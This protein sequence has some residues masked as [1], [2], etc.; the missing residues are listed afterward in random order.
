MGTMDWLLNQIG[1]A[2]WGRW[3]PGAPAAL[4]GGVDVPEPAGTP[5]YAL[6]TGTLTGAGYFYHGG[7][8]FSQQETGAGANPG[9]GVVTENVPGVGQVYYQHIDL[10]PGIPFCQSGNCNGYQVQAGQLL[11]YSR[12]NPG[13][14]EVGINPTWGGIWGTNN[15]PALWQ[16]DPRSSLVALAQQNAGASQNGG[17]NPISGICANLPPSISFVLCGIAPGVTTATD[18]ITAAAG[19][20]CAPWDIQCILGDLA[21][22]IQKLLIFALGAFLMWFGF[23]LLVSHEAVNIALQA[24]GAQSSG[25]SS[26]KKSSKSSSSG[27]ARRRRTSGSRS[28]AQSSAAPSP[29][30]QSVSVNGQEVAAQSSS[31]PS[32]VAKAEQVAKVAAVA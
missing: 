7:P 3:M 20:Q 16:S 25:G 21:P 1:K 14:V 10:A 12:A 18:S 11:G 19:K 31:K 5:I 2:N 27:S 6:G 15:N 22:L 29:Q 8:Y 32:K 9:Y 30:R 17:G 4:E 13:E 26:G 24:E 23:M 28:A